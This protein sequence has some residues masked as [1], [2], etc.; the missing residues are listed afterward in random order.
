VSEVI[1]G[2]PRTGVD[3]NRFATEDSLKEIHRVLRPGAA[4][5]MIW[6]I[7]DCMFFYNSRL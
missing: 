4:F 1:T 2:A 7:D 3:R 6:N 5:G